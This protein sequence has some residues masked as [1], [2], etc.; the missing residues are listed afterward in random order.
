MCH[1]I[2]DEFFLTITCTFKGVKNIGIQQ[3]EF[4]DCLSKL[5]IKRGSSKRF[6][7]AQSFA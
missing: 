2:S 1:E 7:V 6:F 5:W 3:M 4:K